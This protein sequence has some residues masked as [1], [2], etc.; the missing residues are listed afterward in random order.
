M[1]PVEDAQRT[2]ARWC[3]WPRSWT[4]TPTFGPTRVTPLQRLPRGR[5]Q[6]RAEPRLLQR[7]GRRRDRTPAHADCRDGMGLRVDMDL[8]VPGAPD[9]RSVAIIRHAASSVPTLAAVLAVGASGDPRAGRAVRELVAAVGDRSCSSR[10]ACCRRLFGVWL[11]SF[12]PFA[13]TRRLEHLHADRARRAGR[14]GVQERD[15]DRRVREGAR[16][17]W[18]DVDARRGDRGL[19]PAPASDPDDLDRL[20][21]RCDSR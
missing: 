8:S 11:S 4:S 6:R 5:H 20:L 14:P 7:P 3:R 9:V 13:S 2:P 16:R 19:P 21:R 10:S 17:T 12:P 18:R 1:R 15:P